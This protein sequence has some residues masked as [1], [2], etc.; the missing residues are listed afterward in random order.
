M[1][2]EVAIKPSV[3]FKANSSKGMKDKL[4]HS[5]SV[6]LSRMNICGEL[7]AGTFIGSVRW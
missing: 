5:A 1:P 2:E 7:G 6:P 4:I 3:R